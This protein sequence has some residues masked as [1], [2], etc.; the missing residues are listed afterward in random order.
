MRLVVLVVATAAVLAGPAR[1]QPDEVTKTFQAGA[2]AYRLGK[3]AEAR[4][5]LEKARSLDPKL[6][7]PHRFLAAV[8]QAE[9][10]WDDCIASAR[11]A[12]ILKPDSTEVAATR[13]IH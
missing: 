9:H 12:I 2:D 8:A 11:Q 3:Y 13:A 6:P 1:A 10:R 4:A 7:G 5:L